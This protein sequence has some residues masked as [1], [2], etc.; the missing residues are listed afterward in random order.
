MA[1]LARL[2]L[3]AISLSLA[4][5]S[6]VAV[7][8]KAT[9]VSK[10]ES[11]WVLALGYNGYILVQDLGNYLN[12][13]QE[14]IPVVGDPICTKF[15]APCPSGK[16]TGLELGQKS[17]GDGEEANGALWMLTFDGSSQ[18]DS[19][20]LVRSA[21]ERSSSV[22]VLNEPAGW[23]VE[24][25]KTPSG[26]WMILFEDKLRGKTHE[27]ESGCWVEVVCPAKPQPKGKNP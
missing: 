1:V 8:P 9:E 13:T 11:T 24:P 10:P 17:L 15:I 19:E 12:E 6:T 26:E 5:Q 20:I 14:V 25:K 7:Q 3:L 4:T 23:D 2:S 21:Y 27:N 16:N 18:A 22:Q